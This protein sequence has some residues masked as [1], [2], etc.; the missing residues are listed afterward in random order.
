[1][2]WG[3]MVLAAGFEGNNRKGMVDSTFYRIN[4]K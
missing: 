1:M 4:Q 2:L 3:G